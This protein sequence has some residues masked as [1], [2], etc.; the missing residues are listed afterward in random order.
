M[1]HMVR[2]KMFV[3][4]STTVLIWHGMCGGQVLS[5]HS[6]MYFETKYK[7]EYYEA[8][9]ARHASLGLLSLISFSMRAVQVVRYS[10]NPRWMVSYSPNL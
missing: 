7:I 5:R 8:V 1:S 10:S 2:P 3:D 9:I 6:A 4:D